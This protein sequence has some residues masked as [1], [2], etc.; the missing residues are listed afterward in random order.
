MHYQTNSLNMTNK[1]TYYSQDEIDVQLLSKADTVNLASKVDVNNPIMSGQGLITGGTYG[2]ALEVRGDGVS[3]DPSVTVQNTS[4]AGGT[5]SF[6]ASTGYGSNQCGGKLSSKWNDAIIL[7]SVTNHP[8]K[9]RIN[10]E[11]SSVDAMQIDINRNV[12]IGTGTAT[13]HKLQVIGTVKASGDITTDGTLITPAI[14]LGGA[15]LATT[16]G[17]KANTASPTFS[18]ILTTS[19]IISTNISMN[20]GTGRFLLR[21][22]RR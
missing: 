11:A 22:Y 3:I 9:L 8:I 18:G 19:G 16:L 1:S 14:T 7:S 6:Y 21:Q 2:P 5:S 20:N 12:I 15:S 10:T 4:T 13:G 17:N